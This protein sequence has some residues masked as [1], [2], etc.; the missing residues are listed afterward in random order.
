[1]DKQQCAHS[2]C[3]TFASAKTMPQRETVPYHHGKTTA[4]HLYIKGDVRIEFSKIE[5]RQQPGGEKTLADVDQHHQQSKFE[6][7]GPERVGTPGTAAS[8]L[9][10]IYLAQGAHD[11]AAGHGPQQVRQGDLYQQ[12]DHTT[13]LT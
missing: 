7:L 8:F 5:L 11:H 2:S 9:T 3:S 10:D 1:M 4:Q 6:P 13:R 12:A